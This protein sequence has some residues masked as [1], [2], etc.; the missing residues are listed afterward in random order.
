MSIFAMM[1]Q[2]DGLTLR[3]VISD[4]P[5]D[6]PALVVYVIIAVFV[7]F[8][9]WGSR[10]GKSGP[11]TGGPPSASLHPPTARDRG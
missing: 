4:I 2:D 8:I 10:G 9:W 5:H 11:S 1:L 6:L 7:G 3:E